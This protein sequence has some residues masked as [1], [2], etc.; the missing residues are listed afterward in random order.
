MS[1][2]SNRLFNTTNLLRKLPLEYSNLII[3][4][5]RGEKINAYLYKLLIENQSSKTYGQF[6]EEKKP[7]YIR[8]GFKYKQQEKFLHFMPNQE[9][10]IIFVRENPYTI[11]LPLRKTELQTTRRETIL[12]INGSKG[13]FPLIYFYDFNKGLEEYI[14]LQT[15]QNKIKSYQINR[16]NSATN[17][18]TKPE[19]KKREKT[20]PKEKIKLSPRQKRIEKYFIKPNFQKPKT[21]EDWK[22]QKQP[23]EKKG[24]FWN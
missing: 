15:Q 3:F 6:I 7:F 2:S 14:L 24:E 10:G 23:N 17:H 5:K 22:K 12:G 19:I 21:K 13:L 16:N 11:Y 9:K 1:K 18:Q 4:N 20:K 8:I